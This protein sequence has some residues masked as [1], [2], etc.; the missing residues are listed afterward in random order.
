M[1]YE[2]VTQALRVCS[3]GKSPASCKIRGSSSWEVFWLRSVFVG[4]KLRQN[5]AASANTH[6]QRNDEGCGGDEEEAD[7]DGRGEEDARVTLPDGECTAQ[8]LLGKRSEDEANDGGRDR[9]AEDAHDVAE[10]TEGEQ[11]A[12]FEDRWIGADGAERRKQ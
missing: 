10:D 6:D 1:K 8:L 12:E 3:K 2:C 11:H 9:I 4:R 7:G 5:L